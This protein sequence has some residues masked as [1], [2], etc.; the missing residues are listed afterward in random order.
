[1][2]VQLINF[3]FSFAICYGTHVGLGLHERDVTSEQRGP[4]RKSEYV[5]TV[6]YVCVENSLP[7]SHHG[8]PRDPVAALSLSLRHAVPAYCRFL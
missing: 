8:G 1:M 3:G 4:L 6:L 5:F 7:S 2:C